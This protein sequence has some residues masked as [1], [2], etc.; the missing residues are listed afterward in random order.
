MIVRVRR[1][2]SVRRRE[3][4]DAARLAVTEHGMQAL[5][6]GSLA[7]AVGVSE[8]AIYRHFRGK[9]QILAGLI[10]DIDFRLTRRIDLIDGDPDSGLKRL[11]QVL[12]DNVAPSTLTGVSFMV[13]AEV[14]MNGDHEL[15]QLMQASIDKQLSM[16]ETQLTVGVQKDEVRPDVDLKAAALQFYGLIQAVNTLNHFG[17]EDFPVGDS[18]KLWE[19]FNVGVS[20]IKDE[21]NSKS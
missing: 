19:I 9:K 5:T 15:R 18:R 11:E 3:I 13:I 10:E 14:L 2:T 4:I 16:I 6:I 7:R 12:R 20:G 21:E 17:S 8:G 1:P